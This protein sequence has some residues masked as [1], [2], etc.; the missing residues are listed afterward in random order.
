MSGRK[1]RGNLA[2]DTIQDNAYIVVVAKSARMLA[3]AAHKAGLKPLVIDLWGDQDTRCYAEE[4]VQIPTLASEDLSSAVNYF[5][6]RYPLSCGI[7]GGGF[8]RHPDSLQYLANHLTLLGNTPET[9]ARLNSK[10]EFF[11]TLKTLGIPYPE[12]SFTPPDQETG[13]L[14]KPMQ[15]QGGVGIRRYRAGE[16]TQALT[17]WQKFQEGEPHSVLFLA[18][19]KGCQIVGF[20]RQ[21]MVALNELDEFIFSGVINN[22]ALSDTQKNQLG[23]WVAKLV[24][25]YSLKGLNS[26]DFIQDGDSTYVL[27]INA[28]PPASIELYGDGLLIHHIKTCQGELA[29]YKQSQ[30]PYIAYQ[31][32][33]AQQ[34]LRIPDGF[35]WPTGAADL[36]HA[37]SIIRKGQPICS[38]I[39]QSQEPGKA[40]EQLQTS[41]A[42]IINKIHRLQTHGIQPQR[43]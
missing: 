35:G 19:G 10:P 8:E 21:W 3:Q 31:I 6:D 4:L 27:E 39:T 29:D 36:P 13:W 34:D 15:S 28:R 16:N 7:Y 23:A 40:Q 41:Q 12:V 37:G 2:E 9:F 30:Q 33:Y 38:M 24:A 17:Y 11:S 32:L 42:L 20:N 1:I 18:D 43:Q 5:L 25:E 26:L 14:I 22:A